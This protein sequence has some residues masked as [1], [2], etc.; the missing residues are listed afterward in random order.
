[1]AT[2]YVWSGASGTNAGTS[3]TNAYTEFGSA[4][5]SATSANDV[6]LVHYTH[7]EELAADTTYTI[8]ADI[9]VISVNKDSS[10]APTV[11]GTGGW[12]GNSTTNRAVTFTGTDRV[13]FMYGITIRVSGTTGDNITVGSG[14]GAS[15]VCEG[16]YFWLGTTATAS[17][18]HIR[19]ITPAYAKCVNCTFRFG[20]TSQRLALSGVSEF[21]GC[22]IS[23][24][25]SAPT[26]LFDLIDSGVH[27]FIGGDWSVVTGTLVPDAGTASVVT[28]DRCK[29][30]SGVVPLASQTTNPTLSS[31]RVSLFDCSSGDT[32]GIFGYYNAMG[33]AVS[34]KGTYFTSGDAAQ[35]WKITTTSIASRRNP[36]VTLPIDVYH[37]G[38]SAITPYLECLRNDGTATART[39]A[40]VFGEFTFKGSSGFV[41]ASM[42]SDRQS[43]G[44]YLSLTAGSAQASGAGTGSWTIASSNSPA[45]F[46]IDSGGSITPAESGSL[47]ATISVSTP[48][49]T[50]FVDPQIR[51]LS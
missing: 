38:T 17:R 10:D 3:W 50:V 45:S 21:V 19:A 29:L 13:W 51:G 20:S 35:S 28:F 39:D 25:G 48:S 26:S 22:S 9:Q 42:S 31:P 14:T 15:V 37:S 24:S 4:V 34:D 1:M 7:Q 47:T 18:I 30:G 44:P 16:C 6:I 8:A 2:Y 41:T 11:M 36:F 32:H 33:E 43:I 49:I 12:L 23:S 5:T 46:K 40:D 27:S